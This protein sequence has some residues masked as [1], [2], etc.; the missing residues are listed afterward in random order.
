MLV[1]ALV[2]VSLVILQLFEDNDKDSKGV[3]AR[4]RPCQGPSA[5]AAVVP[6][7]CLDCAVLVWLAAF[8]KQGVLR[9][10]QLRQR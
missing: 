2:V 4:M 1:E 6:L 8:T 10:L 3:A 9:H 7:V 5:A